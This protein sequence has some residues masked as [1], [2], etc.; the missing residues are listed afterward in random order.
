MVDFLTIKQKEDYVLMT[1]KL[2]QTQNE[3]IEIEFKT[4]EADDKRG[5]VPK[6]QRLA[7][8]PGTILFIRHIKPTHKG[9]A[10]LCKPF[11]RAQKIFDHRTI[12]AI[13]ASD[14]ELKMIQTGQLVH[15][16]VNEAAS[17]IPPP[18]RGK[19]RGQHFPLHKD[20]RVAI[21]ALIPLVQRFR[22]HYRR[23]RNLMPSSE[24]NE[25][26]MAQYIRQVHS[27][28]FTLNDN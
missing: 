25:S 13:D 8:C 1:I 5:Q 16:G 27:V 18:A 10:G 22:Y 24:V 14:D 2:F 7:C 26:K 17:V 11:D 19:K 28:S 4:T 15:F 21:K 6:L 9:E 3:S 20:E 12:L 23:I